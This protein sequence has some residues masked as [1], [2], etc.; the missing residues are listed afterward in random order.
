MP[1]EAATSEAAYEGWVSDHVDWGRGLNA[2]MLNACLWFRDAGYHV[3]CEG[4]K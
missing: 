3:I 2:A 4:A 1:A